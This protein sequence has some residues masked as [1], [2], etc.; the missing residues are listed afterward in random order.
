MT[1]RKGDRDTLTAELD[2]AFDESQIRAHFQPQIS[3]DTGEITGFEAL[4]RWYHPVRGMIPPAEFLPAIEEA[5]LSERLGEVMLY[6]A[7]SALAV[8]DKTG[9]T[10]A[11]G[12]GE[13]LEGGIAR[14]GAGAKAEMGAGPV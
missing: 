6:Q 14:A 2:V 9:A 13:F 11:G 3:T 12:V 4:A 7:L 8:W 1:R 10:R 5:G